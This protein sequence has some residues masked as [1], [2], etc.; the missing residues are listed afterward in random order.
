MADL[1]RQHVALEGAFQNPALFDAT[2]A[3]QTGK[4][5]ARLSPGVVKTEQWLHVPGRMPMSEQ[6]QSTPLNSTSVYHS[7]DGHDQRPS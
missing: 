6:R 3:I 7:V 5:R 1:A 2:F 4:R